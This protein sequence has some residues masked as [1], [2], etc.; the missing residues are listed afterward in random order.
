MNRPFL[1]AIG[2]VAVTV[3]AAGHQQTVRKEAGIPAAGPRGLFSRDVRLSDA[4]K[5]QFANRI[6]V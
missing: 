6:T 1:S 2:A 4:E 5:R 3:C